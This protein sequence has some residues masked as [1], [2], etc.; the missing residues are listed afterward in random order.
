MKFKQIDPYCCRSSEPPGFTI[1]K[2]TCV[3]KVSFIAS[4]DQKLLDHAL[5]FRAALKLCV[6]ALPEDS[7]ISLADIDLSEVTRNLQ[8]SVK[9]IDQKLFT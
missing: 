8:S 7:I 2:V 4:K 5:N 1:A 3:N 9:P 6:D